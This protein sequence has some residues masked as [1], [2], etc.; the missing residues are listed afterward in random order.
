MCKGLSALPATC[1]ERAKE[2]KGKFVHHKLDKNKLNKA[3]P[4]EKRL[5]EL[6][7]LLTNKH[8]LLVFRA[9]L[10]KEFSEENIDFWMAC[11]DFKNMKEN[12]KLTFKAKKIYEEYVAIKA[13][14]EINLDSQT[15]EAVTSNVT[16]P[17][18]SCFETA[19]KRIF[20][21]MEKDSF[22]RFLKS[23]LCLDILRYL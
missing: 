6:E 22:P 20:N 1:L 10:C 21:L 19:Q 13:P 15:R 5:Q 9:F 2:M 4:E 3:S 16:N 8:G 18:L 7:K 17:T 12:S 11:E 14:K 23:E